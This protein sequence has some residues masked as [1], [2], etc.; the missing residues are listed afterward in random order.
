MYLTINHGVSDYHTTATSA[1]E[2]FQEKWDSLMLR[3]AIAKLQPG[4]RML[5]RPNEIV[6]ALADGPVKEFK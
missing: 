4:E 5:V 2:A 6:I 1:A 3:N